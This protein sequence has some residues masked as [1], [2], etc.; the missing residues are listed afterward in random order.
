MMNVFHESL[1]LLKLLHHKPQLVYTATLNGKMFIFI[2]KKNEKKC[3]FYALF[4]KQ[5]VKFFI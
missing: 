5:Y 1:S 2:E 3:V 4:K